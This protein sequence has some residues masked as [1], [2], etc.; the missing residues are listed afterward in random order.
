MCICL[1]I[2]SIVNK[3]LELDTFS[4]K[5]QYWCILGQGWRLQVLDSKGQ[6]QGGIQHMLK[7]HFFLVSTMSWKLL[8]WISSNIDVGGRLLP[9]LFWRSK[10][11]CQGCY[12][13]PWKTGSG[14][15]ISWMACIITVKF[16][17][18]CNRVRYEDVMKVMRSKGQGW[19]S[20]TILTKSY[21]NI[22][23]CS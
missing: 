17:W 11:Q 10:G 16:E 4:L 1:C 2:P 20:L 21:T 7:M 19:T 3:Y 6:V 9:I 22:L 13:V 8:D 12:K 14:D 18:V 15:P 23:Y 5:L